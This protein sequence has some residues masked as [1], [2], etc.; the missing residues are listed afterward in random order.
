M[1]SVSFYARR[2]GSN[3]YEIRISA[4]MCFHFAPRKAGRD[5]ILFVARYFA[6]F[7]RETFTTESRR[8]WK[9]LMEHKIV[10]NTRFSAWLEGRQ[11]AD[12]FT[13]MPVYQF[14]ISRK[15]IQSVKRNNCAQM[16]EARDRTLRLNFHSQVQNCM[17]VKSTVQVYSQLASLDR[18]GNL[19]KNAWNIFYLRAKILN[20]T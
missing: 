4:K 5:E 1:E 6:C 14:G 3:F 12:W 8:R 19:T 10:I 16:I 2:N 18:Y 20:D 7:L 9:D 13:A 15:L 17:T 11:K